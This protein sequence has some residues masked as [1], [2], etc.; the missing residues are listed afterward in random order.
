MANP[1]KTCTRV[2]NP[3]KCMNKSCNY[4]R[5]WFIYWWDEMRRGK[6]G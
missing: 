6:G 4:W 1:C 2:K 5:T 3:E